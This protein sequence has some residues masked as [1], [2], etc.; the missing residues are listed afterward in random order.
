MARRQVCLLLSVSTVVLT[1]SARAGEPVLHD[2]IA[3]IREEGFQRS[4]VMDLAAYMTDVLGPRVTGSRRM[5]RALVWAMT[6]MQEL[7]LVNATLE[8][9]GAHGVAWD[10]EFVSLHMLEPD[11]QP[12]IGYPYAF[13]PGTEGRIQRPARL[14]IVRSPEDLGRLRG[15]LR[16]FVVLS[17]PKRPVPPRFEADAL[18][19]KPE[20]LADLESST[21]ASR[22]SVGQQE[23]V[24]DER[25]MAFMKPDKPEERGL[26]QASRDA[27]EKFEEE[28]QR[29]YA[30]EGVSAVLD[31]APGRDG[32]V[33]V[34]ERPGARYD[35]SHAGARAAPPRIA[36]AVE[37][38]NRVYR[39]LE[40]GLPVKLEL[41]VRNTLGEGDTAAANLTAEL[42]GSDLKHE[43]VMVGAHFD[44]WQAGTGATD[45]A[46]GCAV[47]LEALRILKALDLHPRRTIRLA[48]WSWEEGGKHGSRNYV[49]KHFGTPD[50]GTTPAH[51]RLSVYFIVDNGSGQFRGVYLQGNERARPLLAEWMA[52][53]A[54]LK[55]KTLS[56]D[57]TYGVDVEGF[58][59]A[60]LPAF[61]FIQ[62][63]LDYDARTHHSNMDVFDRLAP[64][65]MRKNAVILAAFLYHAAMR[66]ER[67]PRENPRPT[68]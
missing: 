25:V 62:D 28:V 20:Q 4:Q 66:D 5:Q 7:G 9:F 35:R 24:W 19:F 61:Q 31:P 1:A 2:A 17:A 10:N 14:A 38:Y 42:P 55:M 40:R 22:F 54:D 34:S 27:V 18:R 26:L 37:H 58:D 32:T 43:L 12:L 3:R 57:N 36:L 50:Q 30:D 45:D 59:M 68:K 63:P 15:T 60:G 48:F 51:A 29:F 52:P 41:E 65:D 33:F 64:E 13:T 39:L 6:K 44:S 53:F 8:P 47:S 49:L 67:F 56:S 46:A 16:G 21:L 11:Y 23:H